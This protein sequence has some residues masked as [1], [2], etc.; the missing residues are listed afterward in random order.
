MDHLT[1][2]LLGSDL[3]RRSRLHT[4]R[5]NLI[6]IGTLL[7]V[8][9][10]LLDRHNQG[11]NGP[12]MAKGAVDYLDRILTKDQSLLELGSGASTAW[13][14]QRVGSVVSIESDAAWA[15]A[16]V[17]ETVAMGNVEVIYGSVGD[18]A[19]SLLKSG[20]FDV[21]IVDHNE[22]VDLSRCEALT[23][24]GSSVRIVVLDDSDRKEYVEAD[25]LMLKWSSSRYISYRAK[26]LV[27]TETTI[28]ERREEI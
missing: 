23:H 6:S 17:N 19:P 3:E 15:E 14:A 11:L 21:V 10:C 24:I 8:P 1:K 20:G 27:P 12:W 18:L 22:G 16:I 5:G 26:P 4:R 28:Y 25:Q 7:Q 13:Y 9:R 2:K